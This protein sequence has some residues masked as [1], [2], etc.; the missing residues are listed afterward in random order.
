MS[1][2]WREFFVGRRP[3]VAAVG[4]NKDTKDQA[5]PAPAVEDAS[6]Y[7]GAETC[8]TC[9]EKIYNAWEKYAALEDHAE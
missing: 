2:C 1:C 8:K 5:K 3:L 4:S 9:H 7:V 6:K